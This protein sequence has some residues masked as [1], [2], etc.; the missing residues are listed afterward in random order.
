MDKIAP[1]DY[2]SKYK[3]EKSRREKIEKDY[4]TLKEQTDKVNEKVKQLES[5]S[6]NNSEIYEKVCKENAELKNQLIKTIEER[7]TYKRG[8]ERLILTLGQ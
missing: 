4:I 2:E 7:E 6:I 1:I 8:I 3:E 5:K